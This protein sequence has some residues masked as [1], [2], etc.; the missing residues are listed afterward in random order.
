MEAPKAIFADW[1]EDCSGTMSRKKR[2][3]ED[4]T[5]YIRSDLVDKLK[6]YSEHGE[7]CAA[8]LNQ[9]CTCGLTEVLKEME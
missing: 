4:D 6:R 5:K 9:D 1:T 7:S 8:Y 2:R 3:D